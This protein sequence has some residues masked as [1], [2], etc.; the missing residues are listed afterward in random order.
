RP[1][2]DQARDRAREKVEKEIDDAAA[3]AGPKA[4][5]QFAAGVLETE[6]EEQQ[7]HADLRAHVNE[8]LAERQREQAAVAKRQ[9][10]QQVERNRGDAE[11]ARKSREHREAECGCSELDE[12]AGDIRSSCSGQQHAASIALSRK[13]YRTCAVAAV[14]M[15]SVA[16]SCTNAAAVTLCHAES[17]GT[18]TIV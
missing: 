18:V 7:H 4:I 15:A 11:P 17:S 1:A 3:E 8:I 2:E 14:L 10:C 12:N 5:G 13:S 16:R 9:P 6:R